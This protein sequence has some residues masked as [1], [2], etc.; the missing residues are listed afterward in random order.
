MPLEHKGVRITYLEH[1][2]F[3]IEWKGTRIYTDPYK[4]PQPRY[5]VGDVVTI[6]H[7]HFDHLSP[8]DLR[9]VAGPGTDVV[10]SANCRGK[11]PVG[12]ATYLSPGSSATVRGIEISAVPAYNVN[13]FSAPGKPFHPRDYAGVG[14]LI[15]LGDVTVY[16]AGDTDHIPEMRDLRGKVAVALLPVSGTYVMTAE[17]AAEAAAEISPE[18]AVPMHWGAIVGDRKDAERFRDLLKGK[19][20]VEVLDK[21]RVPG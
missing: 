4:L 16:H 9:K 21:E 5:P 15:R 18:I 17:E 11:I 12:R 19:V 20:R 7:E 2:S 3:L 14:F 13:K 10:A 6:S 1:D 8:D